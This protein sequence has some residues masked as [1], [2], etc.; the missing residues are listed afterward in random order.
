MNNICLKG[1]YNL[2]SIDS[3]SLPRP[4]TWGTSGEK[5]EET[6]GTTKQQ[7][8]C[9]SQDRQVTNMAHLRMALQCIL[10][11]RIAFEECLT[12]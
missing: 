12:K 4:S 7:N 8:K 2:S 10:V 11:D 9:L 1:L 3:V 6:S 5:V